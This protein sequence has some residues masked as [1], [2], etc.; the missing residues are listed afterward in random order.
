MERGVSKL[1]DEAYQARLIVEI[2]L[3]PHTHPHTHTHTHKLRP[4]V[5][6]WA[7]NNGGKLAAPGKGKK[8]HKLG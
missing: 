1:A 4:R 7:M 8:T 3:H 2:K 5:L 6:S